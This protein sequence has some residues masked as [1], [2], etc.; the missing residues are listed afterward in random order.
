MAVVDKKLIVRRFIDEAVNGEREEVIDELF[1]SDMAALV[2]E[3]FGAFRRSF[4][5]VQMRTVALVAEGHTVVGRCACSGTHRGDWRGH[6]PTAGA[7]RTS[8]RS[9]SSRSRASASRPRGA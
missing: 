6:A 9:T 1:T 7:S 5:D 8:T 3:W 2:R 4:P